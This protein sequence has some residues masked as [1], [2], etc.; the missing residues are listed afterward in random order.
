MRDT[1]E[2]TLTLAELV[3]LWLKEH[4]GKHRPHQ[5]YEARRLMTRY[6]PTD[7]RETPAELVSRKQVHAVL[8]KY[9][10]K[11]GVQRNLYGDLRRIY[12]WARSE[13]L[14]ENKPTEDLRIAPVKP[15]TRVL[16]DA[17]LRLIWH[18]VRPMR[19]YG[20]IVRLVML[21]GSRRGEIAGATWD[22]LH[23]EAPGGPQ[24]VIAETRF[25]MGAQHRIPLVPVAVA[26]LPER[27]PD[28]Q[29]LFG[30]ARGKGF[31]GFGPGKKELDAKLAGM[32]PFCH[33]DLRR[34]VRTRLAGMGVDRHIAELVI[35]HG[36]RGLD[37]IYDQHAYLDE[38]RAALELWADELQRIVGAS[39][40]QM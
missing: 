25:K 32:R 36:K 39:S 21:T 9:K 26:L 1:T 22:E 28:Y 30:M 35:G 6:L 27:R 12:K 29:H 16:D 11:P 7:L 19:D 38:I 5:Q 33:H 4:E 34:T 10:D 37:R 2:P 24:L 20:R 13:L 31:R 17:E 15:R 23:M 8:A 18:A 14:V 3:A 40:V